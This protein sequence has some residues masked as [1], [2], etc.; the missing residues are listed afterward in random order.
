[1]HR[2]YNGRYNLLSNS[3]D[4]E[5]MVL[6]PMYACMSVCVKSA[7]DLKEARM[8]LLQFFIALIPAQCIK[9]QR[10]RTS[11]NVLQ[12]VYFVQLRW[13][14][15]SHKLPAINP[16]T[17][18]LTKTKSDSCVRELCSISSHS[19]TNHLQH[20]W[21][22]YDQAARSNVMTATSSLGTH[23]VELTWRFL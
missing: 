19:Y 1:M 8:V 2:T 17:P 21:Y 3:M 4:L 11:W 6:L 23:I 10:C 18:R 12:K 13:R 22:F 14:H 15:R 9:S 20:L 7:S 16:S 5:S